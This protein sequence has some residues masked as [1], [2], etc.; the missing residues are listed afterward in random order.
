[1]EKKVEANK[2]S[3][4]PI[5]EIKYSQTIEEMKQ[6]AQILKDQMKACPSEDI[7]FN[8]IETIDYYSL[9]RNF[10]IK[11]KSANN[12]SE[13][14]NKFRDNLLTDISSLETF[15][16]IP[17][18]TSFEIEKKSNKGNKFNPPKIYDINGDETSLNINSRESI[19]F[20][21]DNL[22]DLA[23]FVGRNKNIN[24]TIFCISI[25]MNFF[26][27][28]KWIKN[29]GLLNN[30]SNFNFCF[31]EIPQKT[32]NSATN[33]KLINLPRISV[34]GAD[35]IIHEDK[36]IKN[37]NSFDVKRDLIDTLGQ[38]GFNA[39]EQAKIDKFIYMENDLKRKVVKSM[40]I[41]LKNNKL[42]GVHFYVKSK[43]CFDK[44]GIKKI[45]CYPVFYGETTEEGR[46]MLNNLITQLNGQGLFND[47]Q[48]KVKYIQGK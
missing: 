7:I 31:A 24:I 11:S 3:E 28:K 38:K 30:Y 37:V 4:F 32:I 45:R 33:L 48:C 6:L 25:N 14:L 2:N 29:T 34:I 23:S 15:T 9:K 13:A 35:G 26:E 20:L 21:F 40:N 39:E 16:H 17:T 22:T 47:I 41:Y 10:K 5:D 12:N 42:N 18:I 1:M 19:L 27:T 36:C 43:I 46:K 44:K 8:L